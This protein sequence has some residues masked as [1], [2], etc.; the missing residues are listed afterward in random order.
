MLPCQ[1]EGWLQKGDV[2]CLLEL[3]TM[4]RPH[5]SW[6]EEDVAM[7]EALLAALKRAAGRTG[8]YNMFLPVM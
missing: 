6:T 5:R 8:H 1:L 3:Q 7:S 2:A 4:T